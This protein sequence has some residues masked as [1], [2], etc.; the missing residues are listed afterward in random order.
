MALERVLSFKE[1]GD[2]LRALQNL[3]DKAAAIYSQKES[4]GL[5]VDLC[6]EAAR[7]ILGDAETL[8][9]SLSWYPEA[10]IKV[11]ADN[12][13]SYF[14]IEDITGNLMAITP[15]PPSGI[16]GAK[17]THWGLISGSDRV[18]VRKTTAGSNQGIYTVS[19][20]VSSQLSLVNSGALVSGTDETLEVVLYQ[21]SV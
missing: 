17:A 8:A 21:K 12:G 20:V 14:L 9:N 11:D 1:R 16:I 2:I 7:D 15:Y 6:W 18:I 13:I 10:T 5:S 3:N 19:S 4:E